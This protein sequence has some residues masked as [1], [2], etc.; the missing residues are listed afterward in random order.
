MAYDSAR[1]RSVLHG[2]WKGLTQASNDTWEWD[3]ASWR[4]VS[5]AGP[6]RAGH[7]MCFD[8]RRGVCVLHG[9]TLASGPG[10]DGTWEWNGQAWRLV[11]A[12]TPVGPRT[13]HSMAYDSARGVTV[14]FG[15]GYLPYQG[16][17]WEWNGTQW[18]LRATTGPS[19]RAESVLAFDTARGVCVLFGGT[20]ATS[21]PVLGDTWEWNGTQW[22]LRATSGPQR[23]RPAFAYD[24]G[25]RRTVSIGGTQSSG[26]PRDTWEWDGIAWSLTS[27]LGPARVEAVC[28]Y[29]AGRSAILF[30][31]GGQA[32]PGQELGDTWLYGHCPRADPF[33]SGCAGTNGTP[34]LRAAVGSTPVLGR[35]FVLALDDTAPAAPALL[36][37]GT[38]RVAWNG[39]PLPALLDPIG[40]TG[41]R[42]WCSID[43]ALPLATAGGSTRWSEQVPGDAAL[44]GAALF[45]QAFVGLAASNGLA[46]VLG[47]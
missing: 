9:G 21:P 20:D 3:G 6:L 13:M 19:P 30:H 43:L 25:R 39:L 11:Q 33:G 32:M 1:D 23:T 5:L 38:S 47:R 46:L 29:H 27:T 7:A 34:V 14:L 26:S 41:C 40:M 24:Q 18:S 31:G 8:S 4:L 42:L 36:V 10:I 2:G 28:V 45:Q 15:D 17:T 35:A 22:S 37:L 44:L 16:D 12:T